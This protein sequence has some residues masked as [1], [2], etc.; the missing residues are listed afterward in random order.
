MVTN[1]PLNEN[2]A[3]CKRVSVERKDEKFEQPD[4]AAEHTRLH[5]TY[6]SCLVIMESK[7]FDFPFFLAKASY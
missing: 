2:T 7:L 4:H 6:P 1:L 3:K 5:L